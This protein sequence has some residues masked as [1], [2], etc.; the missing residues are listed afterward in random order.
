MRYFYILIL[1]FVACSVKAHK[2]FLRGQFKKTFIG[3]KVKGS[4]SKSS[5]PKY[6][7]FLF[8]DELVAKLERHFKDKESYRR[9]WNDQG[10][11]YVSETI[12]HPAGN[13]QSGTNETGVEMHRYCSLLIYL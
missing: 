6:N 4:K 3:D 13:D 1:L 8:T 2:N 7:E 9:F 5:E 12:P 10:V 11:K